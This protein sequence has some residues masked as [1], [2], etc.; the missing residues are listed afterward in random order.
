MRLP[1]RAWCTALALVIG[2]GTRGAAQ[3]LP[4]IRIDS[5]PAISREPIARAL[6]EARAHPTDAARVGRLA[7]TLHAWE[8]F[9]AAR[10]AYGRAH[11]LER[12]FDWFYLG[13]LVETRL[14]RH[15][16]AAELLEQAV[17]LS[18]GSVPA[19]LRLLTGGAP[20]SVCAR[21]RPRSGAG[22]AR[23]A[24]TWRRTTRACTWASGQPHASMAS[25]WSGRT[26]YAS[27]SPQRRPTGSSHAAEYRPTRP[28][29]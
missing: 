20:E 24:A 2:A 13:G 29:D 28:V 8:Q 21:A 19:R 16:Q 1:R 3:E 15:R 4:A 6:A 12:R 5:F 25:R 10:E 18:P 7:M 17:A 9:E 27:R 11:A 26:A 14:A 23:M 22:H